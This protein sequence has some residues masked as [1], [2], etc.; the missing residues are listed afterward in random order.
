MAPR[1]RP[2]VQYKSIRTI[3]NNVVF[4]VVQINCTIITYTEFCIHTM[5]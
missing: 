2:K 3:Q 4:I 5:Q 1:L